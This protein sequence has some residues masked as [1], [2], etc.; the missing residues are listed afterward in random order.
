MIRRASVALLALA[1]GAFTLL[2]ACAG[3]GLTGTAPVQVALNARVDTPDVTDCSIAGATVK[4][5]ELGADSV[6]PVL[7]N[8]RDALGT[9]HLS[10]KVVSAGGDT[11]TVDGAISRDDKL[12]F[13]IK[14]TFPSE[15]DKVGFKAASVTLS[16]GA[17]GADY[18]AFTQADG[19]CTVL[20]TT[21]SEGAL[22]GR[23]WGEVTC[24]KAVKDPV[25]GGRGDGTCI[26]L[27]EFR[28]EN[29][30]TE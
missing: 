10:C 14:G 21:P 22:R 27:A 5:G 18:A 23:V 26:T 13:A 4:V 19:A 6:T 17:A 25:I 29:C 8:S 3:D 7:D 1:L 28:F 2:P 12:L 15:T 9:Y 20:Y 16:N 24:A 11:F 30:V